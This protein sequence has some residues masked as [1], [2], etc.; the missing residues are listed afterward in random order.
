MVLAQNGRIRS[1]VGR[2]WM[3][4][5]ATES[6]SVVIPDFEWSAKMRVAGLGLGRAMDTPSNGRGRMHLRLL[7]ALT[8]VDA[9]GPEIDQGALVRWLN[10]TIS[11]LQVWATDTFSWKPIGQTSAVAV[12]ELGPQ[13][14][15]A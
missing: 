15:R 12:I 10:E 7:G 1:D 2:R 4:F 13:R 11:F 3:K 5:S 8:V 9:D 14:V 6:Y